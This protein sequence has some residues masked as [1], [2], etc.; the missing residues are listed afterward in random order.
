L[1]K[2]LGKQLLFLTLAQAIDLGHKSMWLG[3]W[4]ENEAAIRFYQKWG[5]EQKSAHNFMLGSD[6]QN[7]WL[8]TRSLPKNIALLNKEFQ[9]E[10]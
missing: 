8:M 2:G 4:E 6:L 3:V 10:I 5:F 9:Y 7:D 1:G